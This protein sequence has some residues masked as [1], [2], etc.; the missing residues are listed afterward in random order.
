LFAWEVLKHKLPAETMVGSRGYLLTL[1]VEANF[2]LFMEKIKPPLLIKTPLKFENCQCKAVP[3]AVSSTS[4]FCSR[5]SNIRTFTD[6]LFLEK[7]EL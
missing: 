5:K 7:Y 3:R 1:I 2:I 4:V 6:S